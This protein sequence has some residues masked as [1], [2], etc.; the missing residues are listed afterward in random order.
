MNRRLELGALG[1]ILVIT[2]IVYFPTLAYEFTNWDDPAYVAENPHVARPSVQSLALVLDPRTR[3]ASEWSPVVT[4][5][6]ML[7]RALLG[8]GPRVAHA[9]NGILHLAC[10]I[11]VWAVL[12]TYGAP[13]LVVVP[14]TLLFALHP[15]QVE[16]VAWVAGR[17]TLLATALSLA[18][19]LLY[20]RGTFRGPRASV[21]L[22]LYLLALGSKATA[23][24]LPVW[25]LV[26]GL[27]L[28]RVRLRRQAPWVVVMLLLALGRGLLTI[29]AQEVAT[30]RASDLGLI[31]RLE[32]S[33][34]VVL[35][36]IRQLLWP[37][38]L[39]AYYPWESP[40][41]AGLWAWLGIAALALAVAGLARRDPR[42]G[43]F[44]LFA[45]I[46]LL[47]TM[48]LL[49]APYFQ[50]DRYLYPVMPA[51]AYIVPALLLRLP[52]VPARV[53][54]GLLCAG[55][56]AL[57]PIARARSSIWSDSVSLWGD[58]L[59]CA[60]RFA[61]GWSNLGL[62]EAEAGNPEAGL[63][64]FRRAIEVDPSYLPA[65]ANEGEMLA[66]MGRPQPAEQVLRAGLTHGEHPD[67]LNNLG[68]LLLAENPARSVALASRAVELDPRHAAAWDTLGAAHLR[69]GD[70]REA[71]T[72]LE[73]GIAL[74]P[75][76]PELH[77]HLGRTSIEARPVT[78]TLARAARPTAAAILLAGLVLLAHGRALKAEF[79]AW[80]DL[81]YVTGNP[82]VQAHSPSRWL[83]ILDPRVLV[84]E[85]W[86]PVG[87]ATH[88]VERHLL[89]G[90]PAIYHA[91]NL[92]I[93]LA[94]AVA[95]L[96]L[97]QAL[98][99]PTPLALG[100]AGLYAVHPLQVESVAWVAARKNL[101]S[102][103]F[104]L[105]SAWT[106]LGARSKG[107]R[108]GALGLF[109]LAIASKATVVVLPA[110]L[111]GIHLLRRERPVSRWVLA[112]LPFFVVGLARGIYSLVTQSGA[113]LDTAALGISGRMAV[114]GPV[115]LAY[116]R[117]VFWPSDLALL[118]PWPALGWADPRVLGAWAAVGVIVAGVALFGRRDRR[119]LELAWLVPVALFPT[120]N[121][122][123]A[124]FLQADRYTHL[125][126][127]GVAGLIAIALERAVRGR[128]GLAAALLI[129]WALLLVPI[130][131]NRT[132]VWL[133]SERLWEDA[134]EH[135]P[136]FAP[137][138]SNLG[139][140]L[141]VQGRN[142]EA[143]DH[144]QRAT[145]LEPGR[146]L[147]QVNL[148]AGLVSDS[149]LDEARRLLEEAVERNPDL[150]D[151]FGTLA[152]IA[153]R[154]G[155]ADDAY[156]LAQH[157]ASLR[158][159]DPLLEVHIPEALAALGRR[160]EAIAHYRQ[161][162]RTYPVAEVILG[163]ADQ[164]REAG[165]FD[166]AEA[167]YRRFLD[168]QPGH[169]E[170]LYNLAT[171]RL[172]AGDNA[173]ALQLYDR[174]LTL[175]PSRAEA[176]NNRGSALLALGRVA[177]SRE[178]YARAVAL[179]PDDPRFNTNLANVLGALGRCSEALPLYQRALSVEP[180]SAVARLNR[181]SCLLQVG[182]REEAVG[183]LDDLRAEGVYPERV[184]KLLAAPSE[185]AVR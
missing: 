133:D 56:L 170:A 2:S 115:L 120:L 36:Y 152:V 49:P 70:A 16:S 157:A 160:E 23:V 65:Y 98:G 125:P 11:L 26:A 54:L 47:P 37:N 142:E 80:D 100:A 104:F 6:H 73:H 24:V 112:L 87:T 117:Q 159:G 109:L 83:E 94:C 53:A 84:V 176:H 183:I 105:L 130:S 57:A 59:A 45:S 69:L 89:G 177:E 149:E 147:W 139:L 116:A 88:L 55:A 40:G 21:G 135:N 138:H 66:R 134:L 163:W 114:M 62:A 91:T 34:P 132:E 96:G 8:G 67:L 18:A 129:G 58:T 145:E 174:L 29:G 143:L 93:Q 12:R 5:S 19:L 30:Q 14:G 71:Q 124:P 13:L 86:T 169:P 150:P 161:I 179:T 102:T 78:G 43:L 82:H 35:T 108:A 119:A 146:A 97:L 15:L 39:C 153:L 127:V 164:E 123:A 106:Y 9:G 50:A 90:D 155:R 162:A 140:A 103:L 44:G 22:C 180:T 113:V 128:S 17:K 7:E 182:R 74:R 76:I 118:Y 171:L 148:A 107:G 175:E 46:A 144:L 33:G 68:W 131:R 85:E 64:A 137:G 136:A 167:L 79:V 28:D 141:L 158:P 31:V 38:P 75:D 184:E 154:E 72:A 77:Y 25:I 126:L 165:R 151:A 4:V 60:P 181:A 27:L 168:D 178:A 185:G 95:T 42:L 41:P 1:A 3:V 122:F 81:Q 156:D 110:W 52:R 99:L 173:E 121:L 63:R 32:I 172:N 166:Q 10:V 20:E 111:A 92:V 51:L 48:N 61:A 101:L